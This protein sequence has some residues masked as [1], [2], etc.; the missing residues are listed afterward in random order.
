MNIVVLERSSVGT[1]VSVDSFGQF[2]KLTCYLNTAPED[3]ADR[4]ADAHII[5]CN[6]LPMNAHTLK[7]AACVQLICQFA[8]GYDNIDLDYCQS[9]GIYVCNVPDYCSDA[10]AQHTFAMLFYVLEKLRHYDDFVKSGAY[11]AQDRFSNFDLPFMEISGKT[12]GIIGLGHI[13][14]RVA[15]IASAFGCRV[16]YYSVSGQDRSTVYP[17]VSLDVLASSSD[18]LSLHC[19]LT[20]RTRHLISKDVLAQMKPSSILIN[21]ARGPIIDSTALYDA[22]I[23]NTILAAG[24]DVLEQEPMR[25]DDPLAGFK[26]SSRLLITPHMGWAAI[27]ARRR[28]VDETVKNIQAFLAH[29]ERNRIC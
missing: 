13:G 23:S 12:W 16:I 11:A 6:K 10:V 9:R 15:D 27:E 4:V 21:V 19:P 26:D 22:L 17:R 3:V 5:I 14:R 8:T 18:I 1:D 24:L 7:K 25:P 28:L 20:D 29:K 2:G